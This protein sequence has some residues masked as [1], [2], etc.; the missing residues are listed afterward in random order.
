MP[1]TRIAVL[2]AVALLLLGALVAGCGM[3]RD[4]MMGMPMGREEPTFEEVK[5]TIAE[6]VEADSRL[7]GGFFTHDE[8]IGR[9]RKLSL[10]K[11]HDQVQRLAEGGYFDCVD[12][13]DMDSGE[14]V[15]LDFTLQEG[16]SGLEV[17][18]I[19]IHKVNGVDRLKR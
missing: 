7:R 9:T 5:R 16:K 1:K 4:H 11:V 17:V 6:Y 19:V 13:K 14:M 12:F 2:S 10:V 8:E 18:K 3:M 15:D